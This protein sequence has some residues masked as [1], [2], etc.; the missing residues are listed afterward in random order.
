MCAVSENRLGPFALRSTNSAPPSTIASSA[1][2]PI[3][4]SR[5]PIRAGALVRSCL[6]RPLLTTRAR[7]AAVSRKVAFMFARS[8]PRKQKLD[9]LDVYGLGALVAL[10]RVI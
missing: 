2:T 7:I 1:H 8:K 10:L 6:V 4:P 5:L 9:R 3:A